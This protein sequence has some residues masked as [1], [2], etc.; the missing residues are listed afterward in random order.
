MASPLL[1]ATLLESPSPDGSEL[2]AL[3]ASVEWLEVRAD[4]V[5]DI[6]PDWLRNY[7]RGKLLY[8]LRNHDGPDRVQR[9]K[10]A[11]RYYDQIELDSETDLSDELLQL[12]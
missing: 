1:I 3:P 2:T 4:R 7:F 5:G 11:A 6:D 12:I 8:S 9:L 10:T